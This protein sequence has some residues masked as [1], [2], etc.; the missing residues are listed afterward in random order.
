MDF[1]TFD[2][3][4]DPTDETLDA[5]EAWQPDFDGSDGEP[6]DQLIQFCRDAWNMDY[7]T[8]R[9]ESDEGETLIC[10]VTGGWSSNEMVASAM[11]RNL[12]FRAMCWHSSYRGGLTKF[13]LKEKDGKHA[14]REG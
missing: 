12:M 10:F 3:L 13:V 7:G 8:I 1:P 4:G 11:M 5:I 14:N 6:W 9:N 2:N